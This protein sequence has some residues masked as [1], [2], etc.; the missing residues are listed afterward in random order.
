E[1]GRRLSSDFPIPAGNN[2][3]STISHAAA[4]RISSIPQGSAPFY[5]AVAV[6]KLGLEAV[7]F[8]IRFSVPATRRCQSL[9]EECVDRVRHRSHGTGAPVL[10]YQMFEIALV[11]DV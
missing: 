5:S 6:A 7:A 10:R 4:R 11:G 8:C 2:R 9:G 1:N 3:R